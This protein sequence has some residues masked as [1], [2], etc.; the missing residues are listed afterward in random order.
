MKAEQHLL[1]SSPESTMRKLW[2][3]ITAQHARRRCERGVSNH[4]QLFGWVLVIKIFYTHRCYSFPF[5]PEDIHKQLVPS[6]VP[7]IGPI[8]Y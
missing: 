5:Y 1:N 4:E 7:D 6:G 2:I 3:P 8:D